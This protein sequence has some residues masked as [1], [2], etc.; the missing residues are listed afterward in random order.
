LPAALLVL[1]LH[2]FV[3]AQQ[4]SWTVAQQP[5]ILVNGSPVLFRVTAPERLT[6]LEGMWLEHQIAFR[7]QPKCNCWY[8]IAGVPLDTR[9]GGY[10]VELDGVTG[11][12]A[13]VKFS[14]DIVV[15]EGQYPSTAITLAPQYVEPPKQTQP[16]IEQEQA[17][18]KSL[19]SQTSPDAI[20]RGSFEAPAQ[21]GV[22]GVF[23]SAR[24][25]NG[26]KRSQHLGMDF[27]VPTGTPI[28]AT[29]AGTV[30][31]A[32]NLYYE[33]NCV[34]L[35]HG[36][37]LITIYMHL[38]QLKVK[39]GEK[40]KRGQ[41]LALSGGTGRATAPHLHFAVR[42]QGEYLNPAVLLKLAP[43]S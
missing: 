11:S 21:A 38:S 23:G 24:V 19:F 16:R 27:R 43:P 37:G 20:W 4:R 22:S 33:G 15:H 7:L 36:Q 30:L 25:L 42:W 28:H 8:A 18:K 14:R 26:V 6:S 9:P 2:S 29:N 12:G 40:V 17:L 34:A 10:R 13:K 39:E 32:R 41:L 3:A 5:R 35:D 1:W 31:L